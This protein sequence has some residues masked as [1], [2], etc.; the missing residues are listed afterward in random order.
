M[1]SPAPGG[2]YANPV[3]EATGIAPWRGLAHKSCPVQAMIIHSVSRPK[4]TGLSGPRP[5][6]LSSFSRLGHLPDPGKVR[7]ALEV[8]L[9]HWRPAPRRRRYCRTALTPSTRS[10]SGGCRS[11]GLQLATTSGPAA[12]RQRVADREGSGARPQDGRRDRADDHRFAQGSGARRRV[13]S[14]TRTYPRQ[15]GGT[16]NPQLSFDLL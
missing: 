11:T 2:P 9:I 12:D 10:I 8:E 14:E 16:Q 6:W 15:S 7:L 13:A 3:I 4:T 1:M 5:V